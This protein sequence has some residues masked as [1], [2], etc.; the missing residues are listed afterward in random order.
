M[1]RTDPPEDGNPILDFRRRFA[2]WNNLSFWRQWALGGSLAALALLAVVVL[3]RAGQSPLRRRA[4]IRR[5]RSGMAGIGKH[6]GRRAV[7]P[8]VGRGARGRA[9]LRALGDFG[10]RYAAVARDD[11]GDRRNRHT[12]GRR[13]RPP[14]R[15]R[16]RSRHR[17]A[18]RVADSI[19]G[20][21]DILGTAVASRTLMSRSRSSRA[22]ARRL[23]HVMP[24]LVPGIHV[25]PA[26]RPLPART[27]TPQ[28]VDARNKSGH[29]ERSGEAGKTAKPMRSH[30]NFKIR[31][32]K[33]F[34]A[35]PH[36]DPLP[37]GGRGRFVAPP[38]AP[39]LLPSRLPRIAVRGLREGP[40]EGRIHQIH[41][42]TWG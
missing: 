31:T 13:T 33:H 27:A 37:R 12:A 42:V 25:P 3:D 11:P 32:P 8:A 16:Q 6:R 30:T 26:A 5:G 20:S 36:P 7:G 2:L 38:R 21:R 39:H 40:G 17:S 19:V 15:R 29:D 9:T 14:D 24:G 18:G 10:G 23:H 41:V 28:D 34:P 1:S 22:L 35:P 4:A